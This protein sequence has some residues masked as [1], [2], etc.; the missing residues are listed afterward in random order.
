MSEDRF[1][2]ILKRA[3]EEYNPPPEPPREAIW[4]A[5]ERRRE[6]KP[7]APERR[8][9]RFHW[10]WLPAAAAAVLVMGILIGRPWLPEHPSQQVSR[11]EPDTSVPQTE[12]SAEHSDS[13]YQL[14]A[15]RFLG[16]VDA[17]LTEFRSGSPATQTNGDLFHWAEDLL[18]ETRLLMDSPA[19]QD[20]EM[21]RLFSDLELVLAQIV[22]I[23]HDRDAQEREWIE[24]DLEN[25]NLFAR[26]RTKVPAGH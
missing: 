21:E 6:G 17:L 2:D 8:E 19:A 13:F 7:S 11:V 3:K 9:R 10:A 5:I 20:P 23:S 15:A 16:R 24:D 25:R 26:L 4:A 1:E 18:G 12:G 14:T 22:Q